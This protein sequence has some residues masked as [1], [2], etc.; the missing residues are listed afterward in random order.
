MRAYIDLIYKHQKKF[1]ALFILLNLLALYGVFQLKIETSFDVFKVSDSEYLENLSI[2]EDQF[3]T[4]DQTIVMIEDAIERR[5]EIE[6]F[7]ADIAALEGVRLLKG[8]VIIQN[9]P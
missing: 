9:Y 4:S 6:Q 1:L 8:L 7:E 2:L 3:P 5:S